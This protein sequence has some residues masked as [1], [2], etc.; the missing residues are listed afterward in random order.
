MDNSKAELLK[1]ISKGCDYLENIYGLRPKLG[2][3]QFSLYT[4]FEHKYYDYSTLNLQAHKSKFG[5]FS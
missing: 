5:G 4:F 3:N 1:Q 2:L